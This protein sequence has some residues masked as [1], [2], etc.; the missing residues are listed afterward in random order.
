M[1]D[2]GLEMDAHLNIVEWAYILPGRVQ[3]LRL[4][5]NVYTLFDHVSWKTK[6]LVRVLPEAYYFP[7][8]VMRRPLTLVKLWTLRGINH[9]KC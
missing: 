8:S 7:L 3:K 4:S 6:Q 9:Q 2:R 5:A 1:N